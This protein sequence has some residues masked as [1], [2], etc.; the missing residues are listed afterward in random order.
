[1]NNKILLCNFE[2]QNEINKRILER[3]I[4]ISNN[5]NVINTR[6]QCT[7]Y[8]FPI[9]TNNNQSKCFE[10]KNKECFENYS[11]RIDTE[12]ELKNID[13]L[14][15]NNPKNCYIPSSICD[16]YTNYMSPQIEDNEN[17]KYNKEHYFINNIFN[18]DTRQELKN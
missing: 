13:K 7:K 10:L 3:N 16:L 5:I 8:N 17:K 6:S 11:S 18:T 9:M 14:L 4:P 1:M 2:N 12:S 15:N